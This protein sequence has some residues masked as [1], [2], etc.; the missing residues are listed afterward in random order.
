MASLALNPAPSAPADDT[1][2]A[3][4]MS[5]GVDSSAVAALLQSE[6]R[7]LVGLTL[8]RPTRLPGHAELEMQHVMVPETIC[9]LLPFAG[10]AQARWPICSAC[11][12]MCML[13]AHLS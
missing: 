13:G 7:S 12:L 9:S 11:G 10:I 3:V 1:T 8:Q 4:A 6:G 2:I 5:G